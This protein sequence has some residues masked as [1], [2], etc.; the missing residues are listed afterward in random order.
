[1]PPATS[2]VE[3]KNLTYRKDMLRLSARRA[4]R[5]QPPAGAPMDF[6][7]PGELFGIDF[8]HEPLP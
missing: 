1:M 4:A 7:P 6:T 5:G 3:C 8:V 2:G